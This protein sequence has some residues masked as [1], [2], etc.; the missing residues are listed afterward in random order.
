LILL[1]YIFTGTDGDTSVPTGDIGDDPHFFIPLPNGDNLCFSIQGQPDFM[2]SL[3][4]DKYVQLNAQFVLP[5]SDESNTIANVSTFLG[6]LGL[7]LRCPISNKPTIIKVSAQ[8]HSIHF[9]NN[10]IV[11]DDKPIKVMVSCDS[12]INVTVAAEVQEKLKDETA[13]LYLSTEYGFGMKVRFYKKH[14]DLMILGNGG[15]TI[16]ADGLMGEDLLIAVITTCTFLVGQFMG[17][18]VE[19]DTD[20]HIL[21][22]GYHAPIAVVKG[23]AWHFL[24]TDEQCWYDRS[25]D[26]Q[27]AGVIQGSYLD[28]LVKELFPS[29]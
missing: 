25:S 5:A 9:G 22:I 17:K 12:S 24:G 16:E 2:F 11:V 20:Y 29:P 21:K 19:I 14:L 10:M 18:D 15:L 1:Y 28:Y 3:I 7:L 26:N 6:N 8:D 27:G 23:P 13:W 4:K